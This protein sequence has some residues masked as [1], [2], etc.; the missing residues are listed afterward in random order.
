[1]NTTQTTP[2][3]FDELEMMREG[4]IEAT[5][6][7]GDPME[8]DYNDQRIRI[9]IQNLNG[10]N[11]EKDGGKWTYICQVLESIKVDVACF[12]ELNTD[13]N[14][15]TIRRKME[16]IAQQH[17]SQNCLVMAASKYETATHYKPG[18][19]AILAM[20][21]ITTNIKSHTRDRMGRWTSFCLTT[22]TTNRKIRIISAYQVC[23]NNSR[24]KHCLLTPESPNY[25]GI[26]QFRQRHETYTQ[27]GLRNRLASLHSS[28]PI[29]GR[30][31]HCRWRFQ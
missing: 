15:Y 20:E 11:W 25:S 2:D 10:L 16:N 26:K 12:S 30:G 28:L 6:F 7:V 9:Y 23:H 4:T 14:R 21:S 31:Y 18:G 27:T 8:E 3:Y 5:E 29:R 22:T 17:F 24:I 13:T 19:T 1:M